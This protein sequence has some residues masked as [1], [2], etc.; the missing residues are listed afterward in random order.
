[1]KLLDKFCCPIQNNLVALTGFLQAR[2]ISNACADL[3]FI[4]KDKRYVLIFGGELFNKGAQ[5]MTFSLV[6]YFKKH[7]PDKICCLMSERD[8]ERPE[9]V[10]K[11]YQFEILPWST[12]LKMRMLAKHHQLLVRKDKYGEFE[13][14]LEGRFD[15]AACAIDISGYA[16]TSD[17]HWGAS[18]SYIL[19]I[20]LTSK[21]QVPMTLFPQSFGPFDYPARYSN[22]LRGLLK[23]Y[24]PIVRRIFARERAGFNLI[25]P[26]S[27]ANLVCSPDSV[28]LSEEINPCHIYR[29]L[30]PR[31]IIEV[32]ESSICIIPN[33]RVFER[34][35]HHQVM[36]IYGKVIGAALAAE[37][38]VYLLSHSSEDAEISKRI[39]LKYSENVNVIDIQTDLSCIELENLL[40]K[41]EFTVA[42]RYHSVVHGYKRGVPALVIGWAE[43]YD[44]LLKM[45]GQFAYH[46][47]VRGKVDS[48]D[49]DVTLHTLMNN[50]EEEKEI[51]LE[52]LNK[53]RKNSSFEVF[54]PLNRKSLKIT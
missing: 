4:K 39:K 16:L 42:S 6:S 47:N 28:L 27:P 1:M 54:E 31:N 18:F 35:R 43:K 5:A 2:K 37:K 32:E 40:E 21:R 25:K 51:I 49:V 3:P 41:F 50:F 36:G 29:E 11:N 26:I 48:N 52:N 44:E 14:Q 12:P 24:L 15:D 20:I 17:F 13:K 23:L 9:D 30:V 10:K 34:D 46:F 8:F 7:Y 38:K 22:Q 33:K 19:N 53:V 45:F